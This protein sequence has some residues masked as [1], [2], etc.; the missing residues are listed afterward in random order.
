M[1]NVVQPL[2]K[3]LAVKHFTTSD[4]CFVLNTKFTAAILILFSVLLSAIDLFR[5]SID[6]FIDHNSGPRKSMMDNYCWSVG[7]YT[8]KD[9]R[10]GKQFFF[11]LFH[12][13]RL[14]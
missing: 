6:C 3:L 9:P 2:S 10:N 12:T 11:S 13:L 5:T 8:C 1:F 14:Y 4:A 7:T